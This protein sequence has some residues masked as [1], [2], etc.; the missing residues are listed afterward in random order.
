MATDQPY[1]VIAALWDFT[2]D[3]RTGISE[4]RSA[5][6]TTDPNE[7][8]ASTHDRMP[9]ILNKEGQAIWMNPESSIEELEALFVAY[10]QEQMEVKI[11]SKKVNNSRNKDF[12][13]DNLKEPKDVQRPEQ[14]E[15]F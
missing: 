9:V 11:A 6:L 2:P 7:L 8:V 14:G 4:N 12:R 10:P 13:L 1:T 15:L 5:I 3:N